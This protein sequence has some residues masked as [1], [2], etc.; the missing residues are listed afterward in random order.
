MMATSHQAHLVVKDLILLGAGAW[1]AGDSL[2]AGSARRP[3]R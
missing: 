3:A 2:D 1:T